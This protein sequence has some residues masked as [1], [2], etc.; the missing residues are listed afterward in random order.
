[1]SLAQVEALEQGVDLFEVVGVDRLARAV[2][3][4]LLEV[5]QPLP[6]ENKNFMSLPGE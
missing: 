4:E 3:V 5:A 2:A 6:L 1:L